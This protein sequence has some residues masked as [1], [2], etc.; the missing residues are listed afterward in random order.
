MNV[1]PSVSRKDQYL[2]GLLDC[3]DGG[4]VVEANELHGVPQIANN[5]LQVGKAMINRCIMEKQML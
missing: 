1:R 4:V 3:L 5:L 2:Y